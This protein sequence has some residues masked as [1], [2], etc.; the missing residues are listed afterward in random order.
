VLRAAMSDAATAIVSALPFLGNSEAVAIGEGVAVPMRLRFAE[1]PDDERPRSSSARFSERWNDAY[2][3][4]A[5]EL[6]RVVAAFRSRI[7]A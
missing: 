6:Q 4:S 1:L 7:S 5:E 2:G 3:A